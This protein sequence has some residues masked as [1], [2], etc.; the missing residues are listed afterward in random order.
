[1]ESEPSA[2]APAQPAASTPP[3]TPAVAP[4]TTAPATV[5]AADQAVAAKDVAAYRDARRA[6]RG[7][8]SKP[9]APKPVAAEA[10]PAPVKGQTPPDPNSN[11]SKLAQQ[12]ING[13]ERDL[14]ELR[15]EVARLRGSAPPPTPDA[16]QAPRASAPPSA[17]VI[18]VRQP[19]LEE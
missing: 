17:P 12:T 3:S 6:E 10:S 8:P 19:P 9:P 5:S 7:D 18:D 11:R 16:R 13:Y 14:A 4:T 1:M 15:A 2:A